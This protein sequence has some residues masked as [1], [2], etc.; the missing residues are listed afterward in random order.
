MRDVCKEWRS[1]LIVCKLDVAGAFDRVNRGEVAKFL[2]DKLGG[3]FNLNC[4]LRHMLAQL[5]TH[6][7]VGSVPGGHDIVLNPDVGIK[8]GA[9]QSAEIF[10]LLVDTM[11]SE[12]VSCRRW[13]E[14]G[15]AF[16]ELDLDVLFFQDDIFIVETDLAR[17]CRRVKVI[18]RCLARAGLKLWRRRRRRSSPTSTTLVRGG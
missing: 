3:D 16:A 9:P 10:G 12:V 17:L 18:D 14:L 15:S 2:I 5:R 4:E 11:L 8:Q 6:S 1:P 7:L 13:G